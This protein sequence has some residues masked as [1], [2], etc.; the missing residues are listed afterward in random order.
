MN[1]PLDRT[2]WQPL[3]S[4][5]SDQIRRKIDNDLAPG[6]QLP[7]ENELMEAYGVSRNTARLA[8][9]ILIKEGVAQRIK[10]RGTFVTPPRWQFGLHRLVG[11]SEETLSHGMTPSARLLTLKRVEPPP[12]VA[13]ALQLDE[14]QLVFE[15]Q[16]LRLADQKPMAINTGYIPVHLCPMLDSEDLTTASVFKMLEEKYHYQ[17]GYAQQVLKPVIASKAEALLLQVKPGSPL[18]LVEG[19]TFLV[20]GRPLEYIRLL[21]RGDRYEFPIQAVRQPHIIPANGEH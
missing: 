11:F 1:T 4:Q 15:I 5:I 21:Y 8:I 19:T 3:Y 12:K 10:G 20:D 7:S 9:D 18:L 17:I 16:R 13:H 6:D 14:G 2:S